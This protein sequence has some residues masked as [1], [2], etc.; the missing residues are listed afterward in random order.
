MKKSL[1]ALVIILSVLLA[2]CGT[3]YNDDYVPKV[4]SGG[5]IEYSRSPE[6]SI[7][8]FNKDSIRF[9]VNESITGEKTLNENLLVVDTKT[10]DRK[11]KEYK[12]FLAANDVDGLM[13]QEELNLDTMEQRCLSYTTYSG[14]EIG[15]WSTPDN[16][17]EKW[18]EFNDIELWHALD[19]YIRQNRASIKR[20]SLR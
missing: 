10:Y 14:S 19:Q 13:E 1:A 11:N 9:A 6:G 2:G 18:S 4:K 5:W 3:K 16:G 15:A 20:K 7:Y 12:D 8:Y 17:S